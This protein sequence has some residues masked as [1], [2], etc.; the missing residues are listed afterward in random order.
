MG[1]FEITSYIWLYNNFC[2]YA[3]P[4]DSPVT[5]WVALFAYDFFYYWFHRMAHEVNLFW[6][7]HQVHHSSQDYTLSTALRQSML[8]RFTSWL[9][10]MPMAFFVP[11]S[12]YVV[13][14]QFNL[15]YQFWIHTEVVDKL[16]PL[17]WILNT[18]SHH[19]VHHGTNP[20]CIDKNYGGLLIIWDRMF[21]TFAVEK[22]R[23]YYG[24][25]H[26]PKTWNPL[27]AQ[28]FYVIHIV[29]RV[30]AHKGIT[31]KLRFLFYAPS[32]TPG[33]GRMGFRFTEP[34]PEISP[35]LKSRFGKPTSWWLTNYCIVHFTLVLYL[36]LELDKLKAMQVP[37][38]VSLVIIGY[39]MF[40]L[41]NFG[42]M[43]DLRPVS[44]KFE[45]LRLAFLLVVDYTLSPQ[46]IITGAPLLMIRW[47]SVFSLLLWLLIAVRQ[48]QQSTIKQ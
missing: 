45:V 34:Y 38:L 2:L 29:K 4:W 47:I 42:L 31:E 20:Y 7:A 39:L 41:T 36:S 21:G 35:Q 8:Q 25:M 22:E 40:S 43:F 15:L 12:V 6:A 5:W 26:Q 10:Y 14:K 11:P 30:W 32:W 28:F 23:V 27:W 16:G 37:Y 33:Y 1:A 17:E 3:L 46:T 19:R 48:F 18:P 44:A 24:L 13:H 9:F